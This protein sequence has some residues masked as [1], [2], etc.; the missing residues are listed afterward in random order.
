VL[1]G[2]PRGTR[3]WTRSGHGSFRPL[4]TLRDAEEI[5]A[6]SEVIDQIRW[7]V[8]NHEVNRYG[9]RHPTLPIVTIRIPPGE[10]SSWPGG[11]D[12]DVALQW[13][14]AFNWLTGGEDWDD[15]T[16]DT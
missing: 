14:R 2:D 15:V 13:H 10:T 9:D 5:F 11:V 3:T 16:T 6:R 8:S 12:R 7:K 4:G 1:W